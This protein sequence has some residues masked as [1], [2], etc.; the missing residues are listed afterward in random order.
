MCQVR[1]R[2]AAHLTFNRR[3]RCSLTLAMAAWRWYGFSVRWSVGGRG[4]AQGGRRGAAIAA[5]RLGVAAGEAVMRGAPSPWNAIRGFG[6]TV[7]GSEDLARE[8][9]GAGRD[10]GRG[11]AVDSSGWVVRRQVMGLTAREELDNSDRVRQAL[12]SLSATIRVGISQHQQINKNNNNNSLSASFADGEDDERGGWFNTGTRARMNLESASGA[13][14]RSPSPS[15]QALEEAHNLMERQNREAHS[16][17]MMHGD[18]VDSAISSL[19]PRRHPSPSVKKASRWDAISRIASGGRSSCVPRGREDQG[20]G[21]E[22]DARADRR[23]AVAG[24]QSSGSEDGGGGSDSDSD[25]S[26]DEGER[27]MRGRK[28][29]S[30][31][32]MAIAEGHE[33]TPTCEMF[34]S[35]SSR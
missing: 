20:V 31:I 16:L 15:D 17:L 19:L 8:R 4:Q 32:S 7:V 5:A 9:G 34:I 22:E 2:R 1:L 29:T 35:T 26:E 27:G 10:G 3:V 18:A 6:N 13:S 24:P 33:A 14:R 12:D 30:K 21:M 25:S 23:Q 11:T 28:L